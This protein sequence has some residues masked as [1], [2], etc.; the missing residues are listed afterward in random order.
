MKPGEL[1]AKRYRVERLLGEGG[2]GIVYLVED[3]FAA[4]PG[5]EVPKIALKLLSPD[6][7]E[8]ENASKRFI[9]EGQ[10]TRNVNHPNVVRAYEFGE[11]EGQLYMTMERIAGRTLKERLREGGPFSEAE[12]LPVITEIARGLEAIHGQNVIHRDLTPGNI[13]LTESGG[14]KIMDFGVA[15]HSM[16][17]SKLTKPNQVVGSGPYI[18]PELWLPEGKPAP[19]SD[20]YSLG[21]IFYE[22][23]AGKKPVD[24]EDPAQLM[25]RHISAQ[26]VPIAEA[27]AGISPESARL[28]GRLLKLDPQ[29]RP[30]NAAEIL[31]ALDRMRMPQGFLTRLS[32]RFFRAT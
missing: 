26:F 11:F 2:M 19:A 21:V 15:R 23:L 24:G 10:L 18:A 31:E 7:A 6:F 22:M 28:I 20:F 29:D 25:Y 8:N 32:S 4:D 14:V 5:V 13:F 9:R 12:A 16:L 1:F 3:T 27:V 17:E 30:A